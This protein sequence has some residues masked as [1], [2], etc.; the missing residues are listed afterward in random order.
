MPSFLKNFHVEK[1]QSFSCSAYNTPRLTYKLKYVFLFFCE[2]KKL[3][4]CLFPLNM[5]INHSVLRP[6]LILQTAVLIWFS[7][8]FSRVMTNN[9]LKD[10]DSFGCNDDHTGFWRYQ[11]YYYKLKGTKIQ[12]NWFYIWACK[13]LIIYSN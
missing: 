9:I 13:I 10:I 7:L 11:S 12:D 1:P 2:S 4:F 3:S 8:L 6:K 5:Q